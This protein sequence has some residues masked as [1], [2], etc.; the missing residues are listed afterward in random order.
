MGHSYRCVPLVC[1]DFESVYPAGDSNRS[2]SFIQ[3]EV[4]P[5]VD[6][7]LRYP[8]PLVDLITERYLQS[9]DGML[10]LSATH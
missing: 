2:E 5:E 3:A 1:G 9:Y 4:E 6:V 7:A 10:F 8:P